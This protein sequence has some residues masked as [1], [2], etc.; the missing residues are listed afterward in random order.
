MELESKI[1]NALMSTE[2]TEKLS[3]GIGNAALALIETEFNTATDPYESPWAPTKRPNP[4]LVDTGT[5][6]S[7]FTLEVNPDSAIIRNATPYGGYHQAGTSKMPQRMILPDS[8]MP[9]KWDEEF[10]KALDVIV[11][12]FNN[13]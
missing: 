8:G 1:L 2:F 9:V 5:L 10:R 6:K 12:E 7:T 3:A 4:I 13:G 11:Q